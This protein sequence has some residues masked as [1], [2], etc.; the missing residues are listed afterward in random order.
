MH[1]STV[2]Y[3]CLPNYSDDGLYYMYPYVVHSRL[4]LKSMLCSD[5]CKALGLVY[6]PIVI[7]CT[8][9]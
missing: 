3:K 6:G 5:A 2:K 9:K 7:G 4:H 1:K 8:K